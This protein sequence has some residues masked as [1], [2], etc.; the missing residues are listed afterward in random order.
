MLQL[1]TL[2][3][4]CDMKQLTVNILLFCLLLL[5]INSCKKPA[6]DFDLDKMYSVYDVTFDENTELTTAFAQFRNSETAEV[7]KLSDE[8]LLT[9]NGDTLHYIEDLS[10]YAVDY[11]GGQITIGN[12][13]LRMDNGDV[14][15]N[16]IPQIQPIFFEPTLDTISQTNPFTILWLGAPLGE[17]QRVD[18][19]VGEELFSETIVGAT[20][21]VMETAILKK[22]DLGIVPAYMERTTRVPIQEGTIAGGQLTAKYTAKNTTVE[23]VP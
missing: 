13:N 20:T 23:I 18:I 5:T 3:K 17:D 11:V 22:I 21:L 16:E 10:A 12:F 1:L 6:A 8:T 7:I 9:Y 14:Y 19:V 2:M 4:I 15:V